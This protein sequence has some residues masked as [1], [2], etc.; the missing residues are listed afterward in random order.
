VDRDYAL[1][2]YRRGNVSS[3]KQSNLFVRLKLGLIGFVFRIACCVSRIALGG[4]GLIGFVLSSV[5]CSLFVVRRDK[6]FLLLGLRS[7]YPF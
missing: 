6:V 5:H 1:G 2:P 7:F 4:L 3:G